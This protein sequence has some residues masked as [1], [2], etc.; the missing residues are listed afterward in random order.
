MLCVSLLPPPPPILFLVD[1]QYYFLYFENCFRKVIS[2]ELLMLCS[3][4]FFFKKFCSL[5][6]CLTH[7]EDK[8]SFSC[9]PWAL[10]WFLSMSVKKPVLGVKKKKKTDNPNSSF[11]LNLEC[12]EFDILNKTVGCEGILDT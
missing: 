10:G 6:C 7:L 2:G 9:W 8:S 4:F 5:Q 12:K 11:F 3:R 1:L